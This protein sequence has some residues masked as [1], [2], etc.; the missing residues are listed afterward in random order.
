MTKEERKLLINKLKNDGYWCRER[1]CQY[2]K[3]DPYENP[4]LTK[5]E[6]LE[7][8]P[9]AVKHILE[10]ADW[11]SERRSAA[12]I[13]AGEDG[14]TTHTLLTPEQKTSLEE[15]AKEAA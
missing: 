1:A 5:E 9:G 6:M 8:I 11:H 15:V 2:G 12:L 13:L 4:K 3:G 14:C 10:H 7:V